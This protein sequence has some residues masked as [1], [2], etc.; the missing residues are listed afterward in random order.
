MVI[1][2]CITNQVKLLTLVSQFCCY[3][4]QNDES[5]IL[6]VLLRFDGQPEIDDEV[7]LILYICETPHSPVYACIA[8]HPLL[9]ASFFIDFLHID[10]S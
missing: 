3:I 6:P 10:L 4:L 8:S 7:R 5:Y 2:N 9:N 1:I